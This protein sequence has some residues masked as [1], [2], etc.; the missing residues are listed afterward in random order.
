MS[1]GKKIM[2]IVLGRLPADLEKN[3]LYFFQS[4]SIENMENLLENKDRLYRDQL[5]REV[6]IKE[7]G[8]V[9]KASLRAYFKDDTGSIISV[10]AENFL[11]LG[12]IRQIITDINRGKKEI[13][14]PIIRKKVETEGPLSSKQQEEM[15]NLEDS[16]NAEEIRREKKRYTVNLPIVYAARRF[17]YIIA[18]MEKHPDVEKVPEHIL[19]ELI[20]AKKDFTIIM[21]AL[22]DSILLLED[23]KNNKYKI[24]LEQV[25]KEFSKD[26]KMLPM[27]IRHISKGQ[28]YRHEPRHWKLLRHIK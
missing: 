23:I 14:N 17:L 1:K 19:F 9:K 11:K 7:A 20:Q 24:H 10:N 8:E 6:Y 25:K 2:K 3:T 12:E 26:L 13:S 16:K 5:T 18:K 15:K 4:V 22:I 27:L 28:Y 21:N